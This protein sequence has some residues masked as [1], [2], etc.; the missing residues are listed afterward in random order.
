MEVN[1]I[2]GAL[3]HPML[4]PVLLQFL[5]AGSSEVESVLHREVRQ[6]T[7]NLG[8]HVIRERLRQP[9]LLSDIAVLRSQAPDRR[10]TGQISR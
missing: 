8:L 9:S 10:P 1:A 7:G 2:L 3:E 5:P 6:R 4:I